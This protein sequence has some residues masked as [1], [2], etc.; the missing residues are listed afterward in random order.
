MYN[1]SVTAGELKLSIVIP[2]HDTRELTVRCFETIAAPDTEIVLVDDASTDGTADVIAER[3]PQTTVIRCSDSVGFTRAAN[4]GLNEAHGD[5]LILL[6][7]DTEMDARGLHV[8]RSAFAS[9]ALL[10]AAGATLHYP[11]GSPQWSGGRAPTLPWLF[12]LASGIATFLVRVPNYRRLKPPGASPPTI[13]WVTGA[14]LAI[15]R[16]AW[17]QVRP[18]DERYLFYG[19]DLDLCLRL[20]AA[21]WRVALLPDFRVM[22]HHGATIGKAGTGGGRQ[23]LELLWGDLLYWSRKHRGAQWSR[24]AAMTLA[25]GGFLRL[26]TRGLTAPFLPTRRRTIF[27]DET[28]ALRGAIRSVLATLRIGRQ[29]A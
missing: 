27:R 1:Q 8:V 29:P 6:N 20:R 5:I 3:Y 11:D 17:E 9:D 12:V 18:L 16:T 2:S 22:H 15:R 4:L 14:A 21:G 19:Q 26:L 10:G 25:F 23:H 13:E 24:W 7:S 28:K